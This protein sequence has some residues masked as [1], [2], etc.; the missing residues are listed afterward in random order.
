MDFAPGS[1]GIDCRGR[2]LYP[3]FRRVP[4]GSGDATLLGGCNIHPGSALPSATGVF[5]VIFLATRYVSPASLTA[6]LAFPRARFAF[7]LQFSRVG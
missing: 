2:H 6:A 3:V 4:G 5:F 1:F 7:H